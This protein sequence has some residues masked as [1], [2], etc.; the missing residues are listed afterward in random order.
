MCH[1]CQ[2]DNLC[3]VRR[4]NYQVASTTKCIDGTLW[5][6]RDISE[7]IGAVLVQYGRLQIVIILHM[8]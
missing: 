2:L 7:I 6:I 4:F 5:A 3:A 1:T 8:L